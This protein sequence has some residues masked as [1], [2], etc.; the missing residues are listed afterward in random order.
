MDRTPT[1][2]HREAVVDLADDI[3]VRNAFEADRLVILGSNSRAA[4]LLELRPSGAR[5]VTEL[6][7]LAP[8]LAALGK[9]TG[10]ACLPLHLL[11]EAVQGDCGHVGSTKLLA[12]RAMIFANY[13]RAI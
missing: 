4:A 7:A 10:A 9:V 13:H 8:R 3:A 2:L 12:K 11:A 1:G 5:V 6:F